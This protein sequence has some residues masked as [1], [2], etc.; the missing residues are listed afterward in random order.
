MELNRDLYIDGV[1]DYL[2]GGYGK[3]KFNKEAQYVYTQIYRPINLT[4]QDTGIKI[5]YTSTEQNSG[6]VLY[7]LGLASKY[8]GEPITCSANVVLSSNTKGKFTI[9][10]ISNDG[11][12]RN[13][14]QTGEDITSNT[15]GYS[16]S[17]TIPSTIS[18]ST[19]YLGIW[20]YASSNTSGSVSIEYSNLQVEEGSSATPY[21]P[22]KK[23]VTED[24]LK[25][26]KN[27]A[28]IPTHTIAGQGTD[29][30]IVDIEENTTYTLSCVK[31]RISGVTITNGSLIMF[32]KFDFYNG[33]T[34][35]SSASLPSA[36]SFTTGSRYLTYTFTTPANCDNILLN[37]GNNN[38]DNN[39]NTSVSNV[40]LNKGTSA[41]PYE[42]YYEKY[43]NKGD[44]IL[45][46][47]TLYENAEG[48]S[49][50]ITLSDDASNYKFL[51]IYFGGSTSTSDR[52]DYVKVDL[53]LSKNVSLF[54]FSSDAGGTLYAQCR[55]VTISGTTISTLDST[56][57]WSI[58]YT[59]SSW[60][61]TA[62]NSIYIR[63]VIGYK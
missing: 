32:V 50:T 16:V 48:Y 33:S 55:D 41:L 5:Q 21:E 20:I 46:P 30:R 4:K 8:A 49:G 28:N 35:I 56:R 39:R 17:A 19:P 47:Y 62:T 3:N 14:L 18:S 26:G 29:Y 22:Y 25:N 13:A 37:L 63:K 12:T 42:E 31:T 36:V 15:N 43:L 10:L 9:G 59:G 7:N 61:K 34:K 1:S 40:M 2:E 54:K 58:T 24:Y 38:G 51:E 44:G 60:S 52:I 6:F 45:I 57:Y 11:S 27:K 23:Y 53:S